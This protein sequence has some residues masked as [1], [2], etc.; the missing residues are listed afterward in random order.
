M[1]S[2]LLI[3]MP[4]AQL[5][6][7]NLGLSILK[8]SMNERGIPCSLKNF[9][10]LFAQIVGHELYDWIAGHFAYVLG[11]EHLFAKA[12][13]GEQIPST[14]LFWKDVLLWT[15]PHLDEV[16][17]TDYEKVAAAI[18]AFLDA[19]MIELEMAMRD[20]PFHVVGFATSFQQTLASLC[21]AR[22]I[23][24]RFPAVIT[25]F[26]GA[27]CE[28]EMGR[29]LIQHFSEIDYVFT[30]EADLSFAD[31]VEQIQSNSAGSFLLSDDIVSKNHNSISSD[32]ISSLIVDN[33]DKLPIPDQSDFFND[34]AKSS[35]NQH[36][37]PML[38]LELSRGCWWG[39]KRQCSFCG[40]NGNSIR[41]R[42]KS[43]H[44]AL[45]EIEYQVKRHGIREICFADNIL[46]KDYFGS[47][48]DQLKELGLDIRFEIEMKVNQTK[49]QI[50]HLVDCGLAAAQLGIETFSTP[51]LKHLSKGATAWQNLQTLKWYTESGIEVK[52]NVLY[53]F[54]GE[55]PVEY[56]K[57]TEW[58]P[59]ISHFHPPQA[60]GRVRVDRFSPYHNHPEKFGITRLR[61]FRGFSFLY[62]FDEQILRRL[63]YFH[64]FDFSSQT[65]PDQ[66]SID[67]QTP[68][69][70]S[71]YDYTILLR[72]QLATWKTE[73]TSGTLRAFDRE[74]GVLLLTDTR[75]V[76]T[77]FQ[78]RLSTEERE[79]YLFC[80]AA[81]TRK[82]LANQFPNSDPNRIDATLLYW[83]DKKILLSVDDRFFALAIN[84]QEPIKN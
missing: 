32:A 12:Y 77:E 18:P 2:V 20:R 35:F 3:N 36:I 59:S 63:A 74:D 50:R 66:N 42:S 37:F 33:L 49:E 47:F 25:V 76:A 8:G 81:R 53:G 67:E 38:F 22:L 41:F 65:S 64:E 70:H 54:P 56:T 17:K 16:D 4:F 21:L 84:S 73:F 7:P 43:R 58:L 48:M 82:D 51:I 62:P 61:P 45:S 68:D 71:I 26:G 5:R 1:K 6:W 31:F 13:F 44:R 78:Y 60:F 39:E 83:I 79:W 29:E 15:E 24:E 14:E 75:R 9:G 46:S 55:D 69:Q 34:L 40:L 10:F 27:A 52:W 30:G 11:G 72:E 57:M 19:C 80:D 23:K 28:G